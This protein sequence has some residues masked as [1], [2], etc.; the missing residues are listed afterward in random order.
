MQVPNGIEEISDRP[1]AYAVR[2]SPVMVVL[3]W[4]CAAFMVALGVLMFVATL[5][6]PV[7]GPNAGDPDADGG[8]PIWAP[9]IFLALAVFVVFVAVRSHRP[10]YVIDADGAH[11]KGMIFTTTVRWA[12]MERADLSQ[13]RGNALW[14]TA[15]G[16]ILRNGKATRKKR[17]PFSLTGLKVNNIDLQ[18]FI[19]GRAREIKSE[20][21]AGT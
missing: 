18:A 7:R 5:T 17:I 21:P 6:G 12:E 10:K 16:G 14:F 8:V 4:I 1:N 13:P 2:L 19:V 11:A 9:L 20:P 3:V 15:P